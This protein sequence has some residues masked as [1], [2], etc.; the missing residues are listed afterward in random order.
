[1]DDAA[2]VFVR[3][4]SA[5]AERLAVALER[6]GVTVC[7]SASVFEDPDAYGAIVALFSPASVRSRLVMDAALRARSEGRLIAVFAGLCS[8][9]AAFSGVSMHDLSS[10]GGNADDAVVTAVA[11]QIRRT[12]TVRSSKAALE[13]NMGARPAEPYEPQGLAAPEVYDPYAMGYS[14]V[15]TAY[16]YGDAPTY[17]ERPY[18]GGMHAEP[19]AY[20]Y[21]NQPPRMDTLPYTDDY[22][23]PAYDP[24]PSF[25][26]RDQPTHPQYQ[27]EPPQ[28][29]P[30]RFAG[31]T[32]ADAFDS[33][34]AVS[35]SNAWADEWVAQQIRQRQTVLHTAAPLPGHSP[36]HDLGAI[37]RVAYQDF[38]GMGAT[39]PRV[40]APAGNSFDTP[41]S[42]GTSF[43]QTAIGAG[44]RPDPLG[45]ERPD[46]AQDT[47]GA[48]RGDVLRGPRRRT[49]LF[50][51]LIVTGLAAGA[52]GAALFGD[53]AIGQRAELAS[54][55]VEFIAETPTPVTDNAPAMADPIDSVATPG[56]S[57]L[58][59][60][61]S[62]RDALGD[63]ELANQEA[64]KG[65]DIGDNGWDKT[66]RAAQRQQVLNE[67]QQRRRQQQQQRR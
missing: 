12:R 2:L 62:L 16:E 38:S 61:V 65:S 58:V 28:M 21:P 13:R 47:V 53:F 34:S 67:R 35:P 20:G 51:L 32:A 14:A 54:A 9:P 37:N 4:D 23:A 44:P 1:M 40:D 5:E 19:A 25:S 17:E 39:F 49:S 41:R 22:A 48:P 50:G 64:A 59:H 7:R 42:A 18:F 24:R 6:A 31:L 57:K 3:E 8:L 45:Y 11:Q 56:A 36:T 46:G 33:G 15:P 10:W 55:P 30:R 63:V 66:R 52:A 60:P 27:L 43:A 26:Y 29:A